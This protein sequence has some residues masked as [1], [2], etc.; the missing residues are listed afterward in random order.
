MQILAIIFFMMAIIM[1]VWG[2][3]HNKLESV[4]S[5]IILGIA[6]WFCYVL[7]GALLISIVDG[8]IWHILVEKKE[9]PIENTICS[10]DKDSNINGNFFLGIG[11]INSTTCYTYYL[12][13]DSNTFI[14]DNVPTNCTKIIEDEENNPYVVRKKTVSAKDQERWKDWQSVMEII[15]DC[16]SIE[17]HVPKGTIVKTFKNK[18]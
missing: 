16:D 6:L 1:G 15:K 3:F 13:K 4:V 7:C 12:V 17:I 14:M 8:F 10:I 9:T 18:L 11:S 5:K 2:G